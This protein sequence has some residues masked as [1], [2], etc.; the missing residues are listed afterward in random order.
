LIIL[1]FNVIIG[2]MFKFWRSGTRERTSEITEDDRNWLF[3]AADMHA[4]IL[5]GLDDG[6]Q[7][8]E[9]SM[10]LIESMQSRGFEKMVATPHINEDIYRNNGITIGKALAGV[11]QEAERRGL[12]IKIDA[13]AEYMMDAGFM[14]LLEQDEPLLAIYENK[15]LVEMSYIQESR[16]LYDALFLMQA[17]GYKPI[18][19]HPERYNF[20]HN[21][22]NRYEEL[23]ER[24][25]MFQLNVIALSGYY[26]KE[27]KR[28]AEQL[29]EAS[30][31]DYCGSDIHHARHTQA[32][33]AVLNGSYF[34]RLAS[35]DFLNREIL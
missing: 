20:Y 4:H 5:P 13:A 1:G 28:T 29:L 34:D 32:M 33:T 8:I 23:K 30:M 2:N 17:K 25:C 24:G 14:K 15:V 27:V 35:Y 6:A 22:M 3:L 10:E 21:R 19:A 31:Y 11:K 18:L 16:Y 7:N 9:Q 26:G 12:T